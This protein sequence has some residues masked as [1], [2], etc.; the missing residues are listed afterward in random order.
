[1]TDEREG[2]ISASSLDAHMRCPGRYWAERNFGNARIESEDADRGTRIHQALEIGTTILLDDEKER[3]VANAASRLEK[4][5]YKQ[6]LELSEES[7]EHA[8]EEREQRYWMKDSNG[9]NLFSGKADFVA[10]GRYSMLVLDL[11]SGRKQNP[12]PQVNRQLES[13]ALL[14]SSEKFGGCVSAPQNIYVAMVN[15]LR[16]AT[17]LRKIDSVELVGIKMRIQETLHRSY[18]RSSARIPGPVQC[19]FCPAKASCP[20]ALA[21]AMA[22]RFRGVDWQLMAPPQK[23]RLYDAAIAAQAVVDDIVE[24]VKIELRADP[25][26]VPGLTV[27]ADQHPRK[28]VDTKAVVESILAA[29]VDKA[30]VWKEVSISFGAAVK[31]LKSTGIKTEAADAILDGLVGAITSTTRKGAVERE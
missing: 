2:L 8:K 3:E 13:L 27:A 18:D 20:E 15:P 28:I 12:P 17:P 29:G 5:Y 23:L 7:V 4:S 21:S 16:K 10:Y 6:W 26:S 25:K 24:R 9:H 14:A 30:E 11:K 22:L 1:M 31:L 19:E